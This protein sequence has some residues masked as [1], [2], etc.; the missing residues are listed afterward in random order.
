MIKFIVCQ[1]IHYIFKTFLV[2]FKIEKLI[3][4]ELFVVII[5]LI[6]VI[7]D[8]DDSIKIY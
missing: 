2:A 7:E 4:M 1:T 3:N 6:N 5:Y 8:Y